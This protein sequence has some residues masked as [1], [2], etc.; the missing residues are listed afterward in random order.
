VIKNEKIYTWYVYNI[1]LEQIWDILLKLGCENAINLDAGGS[2]S[3]IYNA[4]DIIGPGRKILDGI[5]IERQW[6]DTQ[7]IRIIWNKILKN[8]DKKLLKKNYSIKIS[9]LD[10]ISTWLKNIRIK[11]YEKNSID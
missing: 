8:I 5:I 1:N 3:M 4:R 10:S 9:S 11:L 7:R 2:S 6:L